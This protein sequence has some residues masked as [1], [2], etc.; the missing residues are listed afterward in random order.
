MSNRDQ[1]LVLVVGIGNPDRG[2]D[3]VGPAIARQLR[4]R[5]SSGAR[6]L[7]RSGDPLALIDDWN[8]IPSVIVVDAVAPIGEPGRIH[9]F[10]L[11]DGPV[12]IAFAPR[13]THAFGVAET[14]ELA[15]SLGRLPGDL[16]VYLV[17][18]ERFTTGAPLSPAVAKAVDE[19]AELIIAEL[20]RISSDHE[21]AIGASSHA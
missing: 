3:G 7:E 11:T 4:V 2:D 15:R 16:V 19:V 17:E 9:R 12:A 13:S 5:V 21:A 8:G 18:G 20:P 10:D 1:P 14:V 6:V